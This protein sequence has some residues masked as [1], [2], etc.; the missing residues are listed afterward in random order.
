MLKLVEEREPRL[1]V[2]DALVYKSKKKKSQSARALADTQRKPRPLTVPVRVGDDDVA[3]AELREEL[4]HEL[5][6]RV[7]LHRERRLVHVAAEVARVR[8]EHDRA[9]LDERRHRRGQ[10]RRAVRRRVRVRRVER[11]LLVRVVRDDACGSCAGRVSGRGVGAE[12]GY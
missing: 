4:L 6:R 7:V 9:R 10:L 5:E 12:R 8:A 1:L 2:D 11:D 3:R